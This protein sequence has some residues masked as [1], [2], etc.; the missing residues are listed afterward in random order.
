[1]TDSP[2]TGY[3]PQPVSDLAGPSPA[4]RERWQRGVWIFRDETLLRLEI[5]L[6]EAFR[7]PGTQF[8]F[9]I[10]GI[11]GLI[12]GL[13]DV[14]AGLLSLLIPL[15]AWA[16]GIPYI[17]LVRMAVNLGIG[18]LIGTVPIFGDLFDIAWKANK[19][20]YELLRRHL[21][22]PRQHTWKDWAFLG[23]L[24]GLLAFV[25][26]IPLLLVLWFFAWLLHPL[27]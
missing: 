10:D 20:N 17:A 1:M 26:A 2:R 11:I 13:G 27:H 8:R 24:A 22:E 25:F 19:R 7:V 21:G 9:G 16:R 3:K 15:A 6:D 18:V 5:L 23:L 14:I 4:A 12:P